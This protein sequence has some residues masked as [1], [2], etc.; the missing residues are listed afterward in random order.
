[1]IVYFYPSLGKGILILTSTLLGNPSHIPSIIAGTFQ[2][3]T[4]RTS[5]SVGYVFSFSKGEYS[6]YGWKPPTLASSME[7]LGGGEKFPSLHPCESLAP[8]AIRWWGV[9]VLFEFSRGHPN[10]LGFDKIVSLR[11]ACLV[12]WKKFLNKSPKMV[13]KN[14][15][16]LWNPNP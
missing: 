3:M 14:C 13:V 11:F 15:V 7:I 6:T 16:L 10:K 4:F 5:N 9:L 12:G 1:M 2:S 8:R